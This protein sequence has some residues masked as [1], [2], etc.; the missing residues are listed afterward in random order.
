[1]R[2][3]DDDDGGGGGVAQDGGHTPCS[4]GLLR[5]SLIMDIHVTAVDT[6]QN[7]VSADEYHVTTSQAQGFWHLLSFF[8]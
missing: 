1:M 3:A 8:C 6:S 5:I 7:K 4:L 2:T